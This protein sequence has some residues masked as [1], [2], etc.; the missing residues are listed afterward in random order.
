MVDISRVWT[1]NSLRPTRIV[2]A[3]LVA[4]AALIVISDERAFPGTPFSTEV[5][6]D[7]KGP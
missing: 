3:L 2:V 5:K 4:V 1:R 6:A 7:N